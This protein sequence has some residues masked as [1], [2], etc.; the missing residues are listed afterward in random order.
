MPDF[1]SHHLASIK[2]YDLFNQLSPL[3]WKWSDQ[4]LNYYY[5]GA[6]G[7]DLFFYINRTNLLDRTSFKELG[8]KV[9]S[10]KIESVMKDMVNHAAL[11]G[12]EPMIAYVSGFISHYIMD[13][14]C[15]P[16]ISKWGPDSRS[17]KTVELKLDAL[18]VFDLTKKPIHSMSLEHWVFDSKVIRTEIADLWNHVL[19]RNFSTQ[20]SKE[21]I[22][23]ATLDFLR[24]EK[25]LLKDT[26][27]RLPFQSLLSKLLHYDLVDLTY[28]HDLDAFK[29]TI[30]YVE[31]KAQ[32][33]KGIERTIIVLKHLDDLMIQRQGLD[34]W[35][36]TYFKLDYLG[37]EIENAPSSN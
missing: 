19:E 30:D 6:Q 27:A 3:K 11:S 7:P 21:A 28:P 35:L 32:Y 14:Y 4:T 26:V 8:G 22:W 37:K 34:S 24:I 5:F 9:H 12:S 17:H 23:H 36:G 20:I 25:M 15:H 2:T 29:S 13:T 10:Q 31:Y 1:W 16:L 18:T 33:M